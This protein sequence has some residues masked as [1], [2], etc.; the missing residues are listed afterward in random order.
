MKIGELARGAGTTT[1]TIRFYEQGGLL[2]D[3]PRSA[4]GYRAYGPDDVERLDF[5]RRAK[6]LGLSLEEIKGVLQ[7][8]DRDEPTCVHVRALLGEKIRRLEQVVR[9]LREFRIEL[10]ALRDQAGEMVDCHPTGGNVC[11]IVERSELTLDPA[12]FAFLRSR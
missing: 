3:P 8:N 12:S 9:D 7:L 11:G 4:S 1:K 6:R 10:L 2:P 5:I